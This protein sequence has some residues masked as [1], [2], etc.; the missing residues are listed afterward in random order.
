VA[1]LVRIRSLTARYARLPVEVVSALTV[2]LFET[3][4]V[5]RVAVTEI[6]DKKPS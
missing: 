1:G 5:K 4:G 3:H 2:F 6:R